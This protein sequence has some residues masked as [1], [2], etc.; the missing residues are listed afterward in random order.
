M[1]A[2]EEFEICRILMLLSL[3]MG[4]CVYLIFRS[5][6]SGNKC[7]NDLIGTIISDIVIQ[8]FTYVAQTVRDMNLQRTM[9]GIAAAKAGGL[10]FGRRP[11]EKPETYEISAP[12][13]RGG[14]SERETAHKLDVSHPT[15]LKW[16]HE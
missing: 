16:A 7:G 4:H 2:R 13:G 3:F 9:E 6:I 10:K 11:M 8:L 1:T 14:L 12:C 5:L 15:F